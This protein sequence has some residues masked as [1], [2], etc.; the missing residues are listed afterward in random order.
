MRLLRSFCLR[1]GLGSELLAQEGQ[2]LKRLFQAEFVFGQL[3]DDALHGIDGL[4][5]GDLYT[6]VFGAQ[7]KN[8]SR[9]LVRE[10]NLDLG[11]ARFDYL[12]S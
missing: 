1:L 3:V 2:R 4:L 6:L 8:V 10:V 9:K 7:R 5:R 12:I 11:F